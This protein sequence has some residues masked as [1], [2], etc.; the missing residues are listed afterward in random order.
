MPEWA[1]VRSPAA[2]SFAEAA[3]LPCAAVTAWNSL[4]DTGNLAPGQTVL[5]QGTGGV[6]IF[7]LQFAKAAGARAIV[8]SSSDGKLGLANE[9]G[10]DFG[11]NYERH[12]DWE[13]VAFEH[14]GGQGLDLVLDV[15][16]SETLSRSLRGGA[17]RRHGRRDRSI[18]R[19]RR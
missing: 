9:I 8:T 16:G 4:F 17:S 12:P 1:W 5:L 6:S 2:F 14:T 19:R 11:I 13:K 15:G 3:T 18:E 10:A 7:A